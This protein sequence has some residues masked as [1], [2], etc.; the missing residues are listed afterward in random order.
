MLKQMFVLSPCMLFIHAIRINDE[1]E[2]K[3][4]CT[5]RLAYLFWIFNSF[6][7]FLFLRFEG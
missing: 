1:T 5:P 2:K 7:E 6:G 4:F 3:R